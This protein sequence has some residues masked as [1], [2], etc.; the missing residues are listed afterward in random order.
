MSEQP[1]GKSADLKAWMLL[2][3]I[4]DLAFYREG[5][6]FTE[7][8]LTAEQYTVLVAAKY[9]DAPVKIG[10]IGR[11]L[12]HDANTVSMIAD[13]M[14]RAGL[15]RRTRDLPDRRE[16][17]LTITRKAEEAFKQATPAVWS[18]VE[19]TMSSLSD[20]EKNTLTKL[21]E[22]VRASELQHYTPDEDMRVSASYETS[23]LSRLM[24]RLGKYVPASTPKA[25][26]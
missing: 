8:G 11:W 7:Y 22:K 19:G 6:I 15:L 9:L 17:R 4:R 24:N 21:L 18:F 12:G 23:D 2:H 16:V 3:R 20:E 13:R 14:V 5:R 25:K 10:D 1:T 26:R